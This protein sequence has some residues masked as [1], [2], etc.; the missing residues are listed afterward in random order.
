MSPFLNLPFNL[1]FT[2]VVVVV[3][4]EGDVVVGV[5]VDVVVGVVMIVTET[6][7]EQMIRF[8]IF[9]RYFS[10]FVSRQVT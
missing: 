7:K 1:D 4:V 5:V 2:G 10:V 6:E 8:I 3:V 9:K